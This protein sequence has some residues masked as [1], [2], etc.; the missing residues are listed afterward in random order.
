MTTSVNYVDAPW[1]YERIENS[2]H[3]IPL[4]APDRLNALL[5]EYFREPLG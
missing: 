2:S 1:R 4:D 3:W 5:L